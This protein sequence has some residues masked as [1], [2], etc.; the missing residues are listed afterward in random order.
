MCGLSAGNA[1][2]DACCGLR[3]FLPAPLRS[4]RHLAR[5]PLCCSHLGLEHSTIGH[6]RYIRTMQEHNKAPRGQWFPASQG[7]TWADLERPTSSARRR[8][9]RHQRT[10]EQRHRRWDMRSSCGTVSTTM[11]VP[12]SALVR[13]SMG[14]YGQLV[15]ARSRHEATMRC[16]GVQLYVS[17]RQGGRQS[18]RCGLV[19]GYMHCPGREV[20][21][22]RRP[23]KGG[24]LVALRG[25]KA[26]PATLLSA[27]HSQS[28][29]RESSR[30]CSCM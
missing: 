25:G 5:L 23:A 15:S 2:D 9:A 7:A 24:R 21:L 26:R 4:S 13:G 8:I 19:G 28:G 12:G 3:G 6:A 29:E 22:L 18:M 27:R 11:H 17:V 20:G 30:D 16:A 10:K 14:G 1:H